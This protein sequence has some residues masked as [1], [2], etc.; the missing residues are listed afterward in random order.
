MAC[1]YLLRVLAY[2]DRAPGRRRVE[3][4]GAAPE[5]V[6]L[7]GAVVTLTSFAAVTSLL[8]V[9]CDCSVRD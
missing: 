8:D 3:R 7:S 2:R 6:T 4:A 1:K 9:P 5:T